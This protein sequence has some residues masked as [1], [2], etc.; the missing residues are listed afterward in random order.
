MV[1]YRAIPSIER[2]RQREDVQRL[3]RLFGRRAVVAAL[4]EEAEELRRRLGDS[5]AEAVQVDFDAGRLIEHGIQE[6]LRKA[7]SP[8][9]VPVINA[10]GVVVH[11]NLGR[12]PLPETAVRRIAEIAAGYSNL[13]FDLQKGRRGRRDLHA[14]RLLCRLTGSEAAVV[15]NNNAGATLLLLSAL[16]AGRE[17][18]ISR[19][20]LI[21][22]GGG[23]RVPEVM[24][25]S[26]AMLRE[27]GTTN[28]TRISDYAGTIS[29]R[30]GLILRV[31]RSNFR[32][33]GFAEQPTLQELVELGRSRGVPVMEDLGSGFLVLDAFEKASLP[34]LH[35]E[36]DVRSSLEAGVDV[37]CFSGDKLL[38]GPQAGIILG[39]RETLAGVRSHPLLRALRVDKMTY[40]ALEAT[41]IEYAAGR[42]RDTVPVARMI[43]MSA[44]DI[45][46]RAESLLARLFDS[47]SF[48]PA[49]VDGFSAIGG[50]STPG[51]TLPTRLIALKPRDS[52]PDR[53]EER[54][55]GLTPPVIARIENDRVVL[56]LRTVLPEQ[57]EL[58]LRLLLSL[59][60]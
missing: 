14:E 28:R 50:G 3:E 39:R 17:V 12:A 18:V 2:L 15:V 4:R 11:T 13:E 46:T 60:S 38:G 20:E 57:D 10:T 8:S 22:I 27:V 42:A 29:D 58:L 49:I 51:V 54:L 16:A 56:D 44:D 52:G 45:G 33:E 55:R 37:V 23:F 21:E 6:R 7:Y 31:H 26:G 19:G 43:S 59:E 47:G 9:L 34:P 41:L 24:A 36:P 32:I 35:G 30:T 25:Q 53:L 1:R 48:L 40:A 5:A